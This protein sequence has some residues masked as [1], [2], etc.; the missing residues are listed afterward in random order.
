MVTA[1]GQKPVTRVLVVDDEP[2][3]LHLCEMLLE[4]QGFDVATAASLEA[5]RERYRR[6]GFDLLIVDK[7]LPDGSGLELAKECCDG[8]ADCELIMMTGYASLGSAVEAMRHGVADYV[9][10][11]FDR[12]DFL[13]RITR[14][15]TT[16]SLKRENAALVTE[17]RRKNA[18][19]ERLSIVDP[20]TQLYNHA[21]FHDSLDREVRRA[22][23][24]NGSFSVIML[25]LDGFKEVNDG[26]GH[27]TG[28]EVL[29]RFAEG[30]RGHNRRLT[31]LTFRLREHDV[32]ARYGGDE[33]AVIL[34]DTPK[35]GAS[36]MAERLRMQWEKAPLHESQP[37]A[38]TLSLGVAG[39]P[40]DALDRDGLIEAADM[41]LHAAKMGGKNRVVSYTPGLSRSSSNRPTIVHKQALHFEALASSLAAR[42]FRFA[43]QPIVEIATPA[44]R[45]HA[46][47]ALCRPID[48]R[49]R[50]PVE[51]FRAAEDAGQILPLGRVL[52][53]LCTEPLGNL[54]EPTLLFVNLHPYELNDPRLL[55]GETALA[56]HASRIVFEITETAEIHDFGRTRDLLAKLRTQGYRVALDDLGSGYSGLNLLA[57]LEP[58]YVKLD[59]GMV[60]QIRGN[61]R[62]AR[63]VRHLIDFAR[64]EEM[65]VI[66]EGIETSEEFAAVHALGV[67][68]MQGYYFA[69][70]A[71]PFI[72]VTTKASS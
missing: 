59:I 36:V 56:R 64:G 30:L 14:A 48:E 21:Y 33:F 25:D 46:Y 18:V 43:Y 2:A 60:R 62:T 53:E 51:L 68:L 66:A 37:V 72:D 28:D 54:A 3:I 7:N 10:K 4:A 9:E 11:P 42:S 13:A 61:Q 29:H 22:A 47:E 38:L 8:K 39:Y 65:K 12:E 19:L 5:G 34:P 45:A 63:L 6:E 24:T 69:R 17:L 15:L 31:D 27:K 32:A 57:M 26:L 50:S 16:L 70:P 71:P 49:F 40:H 41:A 52:R 58:D 20:L 1:D 35:A 67:T 44:W 55:D 23:R